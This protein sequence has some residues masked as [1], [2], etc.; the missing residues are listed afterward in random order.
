MLTFTMTDG[1]GESASTR[2]SCATCRHCPEI[3]NS[4]DGREWICTHPKYHGCLYIGH[5]PSSFGSDCPE[6]EQTEEVIRNEE[7]LHPRRPAN[8]PPSDGS[9]PNHAAPGA[10][11]RVWIIAATELE[12]ASAA[13]DTALEAVRIAKEM[14]A[15]AYRDGNAIEA[16]HTVC[17][18]VTAHLPDQDRF[19]EHTGNDLI[20][21][22]RMA[23]EAVI[24]LEAAQAAQV[25][26][27]AW[28]NEE[29]LAALRP[30]D[31]CEESR[32]GERCTIQIIDDAVAVVALPEGHTALRA[33]LNELTKIGN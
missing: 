31:P 13:L 21:T 9:K 26:Q 22:A 11:A 24:E 18:H 29:R 5:E 6:H 25:A 7:E 14:S 4:P 15:A 28:E 30:G 12:T 33:L 1:T 23:E 16:D 3:A 17:S 27:D 20:C 10:R 32:T 2:Q 8:E 19:T